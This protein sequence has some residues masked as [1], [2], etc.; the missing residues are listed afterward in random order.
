MA[1]VLRAPLLLTVA[2]AARCAHAQ[3]ADATQHVSPATQWVQQQ[4]MRMARM[5]EQNSD[6]VRRIAPGATS[7][8]QSSGPAETALWLAPKKYNHTLL[9]PLSTGSDA[10]PWWYIA[11]WSNVDPFVDPTVVPGL[12][13]CSLQPVGAG[14]GNYHIASSTMRVCASNVTV[15]AQPPASA[16]AIELAQNGAANPVPCGVEFDAFLAPTDD[17]YD[18]APRNFDVFVPLA[19]VSAVTVSFT[20]SLPHSAITARCGVAPQCSASPDYAYATLGLVLDNAVAKQTNFYQVILY[21]SRA[22]ECP[23]N[24]PC[25]PFSLWYFQ[26]LPTLGVSD[27][28]A[29]VTGDAAA[30]LQPGA[31]PV[32]FQLSMLPILQQ[33]VAFAAAH[34]G[35]DAN[36]SNWAVHGL[37]IGTG[38]QGSAVTTFTV[39]NVSLT[40]A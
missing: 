39:A 6:S 26:T 18:N 33:R 32:S 22:G 34:F 20:V 3:I 16:A 15:A 28:I 13:G 27:S 17:A 19:N 12:N 4:G 9:G 29:L 23:Q 7:L 21:D 40:V 35:A 1:G 2:L 38:L 10:S 37:Y 30:C 24:D 8:L 31:P 11:Q 14:V 5:R 25:K 36:L